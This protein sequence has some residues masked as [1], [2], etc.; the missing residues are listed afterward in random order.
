MDYLQIKEFILD[1]DIVVY[2]LRASGFPE[3]V[4]A[5]HMKLHSF[6]EFDSNRQYF[7]ISHPE[8]NEAIAYW[9]AATEI[10]PEEFSRHGLEKFIIEAGTY[11]YLDVY[12]FME[13]ISDI[14]NAFKILTALPDL[15]PEGYCLE[16]YSGKDCRCMIRTL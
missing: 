3:G 9:A 6:V 10:M 7:G 5:A 11:K 2:R 4:G 14:G 1:K 16:W 13:N 15:N 8:K 12:L